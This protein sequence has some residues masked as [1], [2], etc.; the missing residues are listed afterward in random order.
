M[1]TWCARLEIQA[2]GCDETMGDLGDQSGAAEAWWAYPTGPKVED[3]VLRLVFVLWILCVLECCLCVGCMN[4]FVVLRTSLTLRGGWFVIPTSC[5]H[6]C[7]V[8]HDILEVAGEFW[9][10]GRCRRWIEIC[11]RRFGTT[12]VLTPRVGRQCDRARVICVAYLV[13][14]VCSPGNCLLWLCYDVCAIHVCYYLVCAI[15]GS[16]S[17]WLMRP[18]GAEYRKVI[19]W[20]WCEM[21][22]CVIYSFAMLF[23]CCILVILE[24]LYI[25]V[26]SYFCVTVEYWGRGIWCGFERTFWFWNLRPRV[27]DLERVMKWDVE[28]MFRCWICGVVSID[29]RDMSLGMMLNWDCD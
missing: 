28:N 26:L 20:A 29:W 19:W 14:L 6:S 8:W 11:L 12:M 4:F 25:L 10:W 3:A 21:F 27:L 23:W 13:A 9:V 2:E 18:W 7:D 17:L 16:S 24:M 15:Y 1:N 22:V 5:A